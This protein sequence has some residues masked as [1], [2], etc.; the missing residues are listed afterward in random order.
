MK[1]VLERSYSTHCTAQQA[2]DAYQAVMEWCNREKD[3]L[4]KFPR[5]PD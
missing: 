2:G 5:K 1:A 3:N 4:Y